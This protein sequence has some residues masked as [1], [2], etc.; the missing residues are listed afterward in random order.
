MVQTVEV[1]GFNALQAA[2]KDNSK[3]ESLFILFSGS[4]DANGVS[5]CPDCVDGKL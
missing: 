3:T 4:K 2:I 5:W 1:Q